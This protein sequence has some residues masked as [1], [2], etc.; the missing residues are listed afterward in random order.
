MTDDI[1]STYWRLEDAETRA[2]QFPE[3]FQ[4]PNLPQ[5]MS[6]IGGQAAKLCFL[7][8][9][10]HESGCT[11]ER[12]WVVVEQ[13]E[14]D[15]S[16][17]GYLANDPALAPEGGGVELKRGASVTFAPCHILDIDAGPG[18]GAA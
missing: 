17:V 12:M 9:E 5:R 7:Y 13:V 4:I 14:T 8:D 10:P 3:S 18:D 1:A 16:Y 6:L 11:G 15:G 2:Q